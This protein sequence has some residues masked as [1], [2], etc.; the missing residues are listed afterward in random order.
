MVDQTDYNKKV[1]VRALLAW[2]IFNLNLS[3]NYS[4][5]IFSQWNQLRRV[6]TAFSIDG[7]VK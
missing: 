1:K 4:I 2:N 5:I 3:T 7:Q 6:E